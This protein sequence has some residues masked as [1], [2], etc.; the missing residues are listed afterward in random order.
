MRD[1]QS[2]TRKW[3][4]TAEAA[5]YFG[6]SCNFLAKDRCNGLLQIPFH[7]MG[8]HIRYNINELD[9]WLKGRGN[10]GAVV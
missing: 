2:I 10:Q 4:T 3:L 7:K 8:R 1:K 9:E 6:A 5:Q